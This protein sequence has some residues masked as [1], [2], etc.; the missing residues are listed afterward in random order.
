MIR[1][2]LFLLINFGALALGSWLMGSSPLENQWYQNLNK[3]PW[4]PPGWV[5]GAAWTFIMICFSVFLWKF[6]G[7]EFRSD[8]ITVYAIFIVQLLLNIGWNPVFFAWHHTTLALIIIIALTLLIFFWMMYGFQKVRWSGLLL[9]PYFLWL[10]IATS[11]NA[12]AVFN[13]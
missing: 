8:A 2:I 11:L 6:S 7:K 4:T 5:F 3:A 12:Y 10:L 9:L 13:N 1:L